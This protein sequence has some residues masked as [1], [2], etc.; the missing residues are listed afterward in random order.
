MKI[1]QFLESRRRGNYN[2]WIDDTGQIWSL[3]HHSTNNIIVSYWCCFCNTMTMLFSDDIEDWL[4]NV[5]Q[6]ILHSDHVPVSV[7]NK[8]NNFIHFFHFHSNEMNVKITSWS[9]CPDVASEHSHCYTFDRR[10]GSIYDK[11]NPIHWR[12]SE[13]PSFGCHAR[14]PK[15]GSPVT[16]AVPVAFRVASFLMMLHWSFKGSCKQKYTNRIRS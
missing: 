11:S 16:E 4:Q 7:T 2:T 6:N 10:R 15:V 12:V 13:R 8:Y 14:R 3:I 1:I 5:Q 9:Q